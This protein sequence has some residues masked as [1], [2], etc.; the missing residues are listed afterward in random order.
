MIAYGFWFR[1]PDINIITFSFQGHFLPSFNRVSNGY[2]RQKPSKKPKPN[3]F[4]KA[5]SELSLLSPRHFST[6]LSTRIW[7]RIEIVRF[8]ERTTQSYVSASTYAENNLKIQEPVLTVTPLRIE[9]TASATTA[10]TRWTGEALPTRFKFL[11][12]TQTTFIVSRGFK[13]RRA[14]A[15]TL[16]FTR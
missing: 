1:C 3:L 16:P 8:K 14:D 10:S 6:F 5:V 7:P 4:E 15:G 13:T 12:P 11:R 9:A 2:F